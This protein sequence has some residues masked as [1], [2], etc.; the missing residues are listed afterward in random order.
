MKKITE[1]GGKLVLNKR[2]FTLVELLAVI[3]IL[4]IIALIATP[5][6]LDIIEDTRYSAFKESVNSVFRGYEIYELE[7]DENGGKISVIDEE[8]PLDSKFKAGKVYRNE[9]GEIEVE[10]ISD[11]MYC[12]SG[13]KNKL[14]IA[15]TTCDKL[16]G[17]EVKVN[18]NKITTNSITVT[19]EVI[20][21]ESG[22]KGIY[23]S[24]NNGEYK[25]GEK[26]YT[27]NKL[28]LNKTYKISVKVVNVNNVETII[29]EE[30]TTLNIDNPT[31]SVDSSDWKRSKTVTI[32]YPDISEQ[33]L[34][35][36]YSID[37][38]TTWKTATKSQEVIFNSNGSIVARVKDGTNIVTANTFTVD[39]IDTA[40]PT[41]S[42]ITGNTDSWTKDKTLVVT[43]SDTG[44]SEIA[45]YSFDNGSTWQTGN[46]KK[47]TSNGTYNIK[48]KDNAG[49]ISAVSTVEI[50]KIDTQTPTITVAKTSV[51]SNYIVVSVTI[52][53]NPMGISKIE[54]SIDNG[55][56]WTSDGTNTTHTFTGL[57]KNK[58]YTI[59]AR[60][61]SNNGKT[62]TSTAIMVSTSDI[63]VPTYEVNNSGWAK[64]KKVTI[65]YPSIS[66]QTLTYEYSIDKG[67][68]WKTATKSQEV[69][70]N[71][72][73]SI[74]ARVK[75]GTNIVTANTFTVDKIDTVSPTISSVTG[76]TDSWTKDKTLVVTASDTGGSGIA[77]YSFDNGS[78]WQTGNS[79]KITSNGTYN[80]KVK[81]NAGNVGT[82]TSVVVNK[83]DDKTPVISLVADSVG[84]DFIAVSVT[85][86]NNPMGISKVEYSLNYNSWEYYGGT[87]HIYS[88]LEKNTTYYIEAK[89]TSNNGKVGYSNTLQVTTKEPVV[90][91]AT[92]S[93]K[94]LA[95]KVP[96]G[97]FAKGDEY[98]INVDGTNKY[99]F[100]ILS[101]EGN[102]VNLIMSNNICSDGT[103]ATSTN[104]CLVAWYESSSDNMSGPVTAMNYLYQATKNWSN[105]DNIQIN[106]TNEGK[107]TT[108]GYESIKVSGN[109]TK[110]TKKDG[111]TTTTYTNLK[112]RMPKLS[113]LTGTGCSTTSG[114]CPAWMVNG[115]N[116]Y[117]NK[118]TR[119][120]K[121]SIDGINGYWSLSS[122]TNRS[123]K[124]INYQG[125]VN[126][127]F[128]NYSSDYGIR[129]VITISKEAFS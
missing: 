59:K 18:I 74:I 65:T 9:K 91:A 75:D 49:N 86:S 32:T 28:E 17:E 26:A 1:G 115:L 81:D 62:A 69:T 5:I 71:S 70:F 33:T 120:Q 10:N 20:D 24:V 109:T 114:S 100:Y 108:Y 34:T 56:N 127:Y 3:T 88:G 55:S 78:T 126:S 128:V 124:V 30:V 42:G 39:K 89:V 68:T 122:E 54:Y 16:K 83:I 36:E 79:K 57:T 80:I 63:T 4:A 15:K 94:T 96:S 66:G 87:S 51:G 90:S 102:E 52:T 21:E 101:V 58:S 41:I 106:Y 98:I 29:E 104:K 2:A 103:L 85:V 23:Y 14:I 44:G 53:N 6:V 50:T 11:G 123:A 61:T 35:Y 60:I 8:F 111:T 107:T 97:S 22:I 113:E 64:S 46:S 67:T 129:P 118:Y 119:F 125:I 117:T 93:N 72:N 99:H 76:N 27:F 110:V 25:S 40:S 116:P 92:S 121:E 31:Y 82:A 7:T 19:V 38:G 73:G 84:S 48:V 112:A 45:G 95:G 12:A 105:I 47:I 77:G 13:T 37:R 43:A